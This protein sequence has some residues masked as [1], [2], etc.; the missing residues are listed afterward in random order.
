MQGVVIFA[1]L[2]AA[3]VL[4]AFGILRVQTV[5]MVYMA[6]TVWASAKIA[7]LWGLDRKA[8]F[9]TAIAAAM[10][11][12]V[13]RLMFIDLRYAPYLVILPANLFIAYIFARGMVPGRQPIL[14][15]LIE[16]MNRHP[17]DNP[18]FIRFVRGQCLLW[19]VLSFTTAVLAFL[20]LVW[21]T[22]NPAIITVLGVIVIAQL[23]W[24][25]LSHIYAGMRYGRPERL[26]DTIQTLSRP[27][28]RALITP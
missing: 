12:L 4:G 2:A 17:L 6:A 28:G 26:W 7:L 25:P 1:G 11:L 21:G 22:T 9:G 27:E 23:I 10:M 16:L 15:E 19:A 5:D 20:S 18:R 13:L 8:V 14:L 3:A 24:L